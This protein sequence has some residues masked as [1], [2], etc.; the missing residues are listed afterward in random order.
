MAS[1]ASTTHSK[2]LTPTE[3]AQQLGVAA[4]ELD[5]LVADGK[6]PAYRIGGEFTRFRQDDVEALQKK[7]KGSDPRLWESREKQIR[8]SDPMFFERVREFFY[9]HDFYLLAAMLALLLIA[10][11]FRF[12]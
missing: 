9:L 3:A 6:L 7:S 5:R 2:L 1:S 8:G 4:S 12:A 10:V 11:L